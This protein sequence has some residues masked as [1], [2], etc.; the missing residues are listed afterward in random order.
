MGG[1]EGE[2]GRNRERERAREGGRDGERE[3]GREKFTVLCRLACNCV[4]HWHS[5]GLVY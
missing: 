1:K 3:G 4:Q 5:L 2:R